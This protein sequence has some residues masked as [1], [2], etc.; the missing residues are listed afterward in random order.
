M[1]FLKKIIK[2]KKNEIKIKKE[3][4]PLDKV[5]K[6]IMKSPANRSFRDIFEYNDFS[7][8]GEIKKKSPSYG[9][10]KARINIKD[11]VKKY[12]EAG[13]K[14]LSI[15]TDKKYFDGNLDFIAE[16]KKHSSLPVLR[17]DFI[18][19][20]YQIYESRLAKADALL[21]IA[22]ILDSKEL[23]AFVK[24]A[25]FLNMTPIVEVHSKEDIKKAIR[26]S[27]E[28]IGIN[29]RDLK[30]FKTDLNVIKRLAKL[31]PK[32][33]IIICES[34]IKM[35]EDVKDILIDERIKGV[36][37]GTMFMTAK[38]DKIKEYVEK[39]NNIVSSR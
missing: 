15:V 2:N 39:I 25:R 33:R 1:S 23:S 35:P 22:A 12:E 21:L 13:I 5:L 32:D 31:I 3:K 18:L 24:K 38:E 26:S 29:T 10:L 7:I 4:F 8:I 20:E 9:T 6:E 28:I 27:T 11:I 34:G 19:D 16:A 14:A 17:K 36:L 37:I 30:N